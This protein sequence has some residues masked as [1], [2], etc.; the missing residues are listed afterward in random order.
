MEV[1]GW[2]PTPAL[3]QPAPHGKGAGGGRERSRPRPPAPPAVCAPDEELRLQLIAL[4]AVRDP[5]F[6]FPERKA[7]SRHDEHFDYKLAV[8]S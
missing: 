8:R 3:E 2:P 4:Q 1:L 7:P 5:A 6:N